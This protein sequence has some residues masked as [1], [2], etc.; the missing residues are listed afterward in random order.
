M[1]CGNTP[2]STPQL[3]FVYHP[4]LR[5]SC[6]PAE[7]VAGIPSTSDVDRQVAPDVSMTKVAP[8]ATS[9]NAPSAKA[10]FPPDHESA[11]E[12]S[13]KWNPSRQDASGPTMATDAGPETSRRALPLRDPPVQANPETARTDAGVLNRRKSPDW[14]QRRISPPATFKV[15]MVASVNPGDFHFSVDS[16]QRHASTSGP[17]YKRSQA[18]SPLNPDA[19]IANVPLFTVTLVAEKAEAEACAL[20]VGPST[21][22]VGKVPATW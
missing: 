3:G 6:R 4:V 17:A 22:R 5:S 16:A 21:T 11:K 2:H 10:A 13:F 19:P 20:A 14:A 7:D 18:S 8:T 1:S 12:R 15:R 9:T